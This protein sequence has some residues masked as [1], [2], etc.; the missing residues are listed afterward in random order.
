MKQSKQPSSFTELINQ[1]L[2]R[3]AI[4]KGNYTRDCENSLLY[5]FNLV[6]GALP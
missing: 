6:L 2:Q 1:Y 5:Q 4:K 3:L